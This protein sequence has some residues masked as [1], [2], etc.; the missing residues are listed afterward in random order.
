[1]VKREYLFRVFY[2]KTI[3][4]FPTTKVLID[5]LETNSKLRLLCGWKYRGEVPSEKTCRAC[6]HGFDGNHL[7]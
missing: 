4:G 5:N 7:V 1:M 3:Y 2:L 6:K